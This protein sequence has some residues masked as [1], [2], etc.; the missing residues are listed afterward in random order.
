MS[1]IGAGWSSD[2]VSCVIKAP[3]DGVTKDQE[4]SCLEMI[5]MECKRDCTSALKYYKGKWKK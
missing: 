5:S 3:K 2:R 1:T 4:W